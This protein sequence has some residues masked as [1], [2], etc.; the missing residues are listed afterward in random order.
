MTSN[1]CMK[2]NW[3]F[4]RIITQAFCAAV[5]SR[6]FMTL[7]PRKGKDAHSHRGVIARPNALRGF[8]LELVPLSWLPPVLIRRAL[9]FTRN[10]YKRRLN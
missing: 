9:C 7:L 6:S 2:L 5:Y 1:V 4:V 3:S 10:G 8:A